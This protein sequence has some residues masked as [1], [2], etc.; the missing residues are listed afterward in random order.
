[1]GSFGGAG[2]LGLQ[3]KKDRRKKK[4]CARICSGMACAHQVRVLGLRELGSHI[5][6]EK[7]ISS[8]GGQSQIGHPTNRVSHRYMNTYFLFFINF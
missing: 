1:M 3:R 8:D 6:G 7:K 2:R 5:Y 4:V